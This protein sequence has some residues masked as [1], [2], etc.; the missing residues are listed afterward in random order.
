MIKHVGRYNNQKVIVLFRKVPGEDHMCLVAYSD[1]IPSQIHNDV[2]KV[3]ESA[4][5]QSAEILGD[6]LGRSVGSDGSQLLQKL[7]SEGYI[8]KLPTS[9]VIMVP[10]AKSQLRLDEL[11][12]LIDQIQAGGESAAKLKDLD[13]NA[14]YQNINKEAVEAIAAV[15]GALDDEALSKQYLEQAEQYLAEAKR[16]QE[17]A[18]LLNPSL[19]PKDS[20]PEK[21]PIAAKKS[22]ASKA[23]ARKTTA[24]KEKE[25]NTKTTNKEDTSS[26]SAE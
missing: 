12:V 7:H 16:L 5:G 15:D 19:K 4:E 17:E 3:V 20:T 18:Y 24:S 9:Q 1:S 25:V 26:T 13:D 23:P 11:N 8:K 10:N 22:T 21:A 6:V 14:G 2:M